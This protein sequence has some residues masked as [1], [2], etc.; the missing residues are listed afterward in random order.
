MISEQIRDLAARSDS[1]EPFLSFYMDTNRHDEQDR[2]R[3]RVSLKDELKD[4]REAVTSSNGQDGGFNRALHQVESYMESELSPAS[5]GVAFFCC[6]SEEFFRAL[7]LPFNVAT[8]SRVGVRPY[9]KPLNVLRQANPDTLIVLVD[10]KSARLFAL[11]FGQLLYEL[12]LESP[13]LP[14][15]LDQGGWSP[16]NIQRHVQDHI[17]RLHKEVAETLS[18]KLD[19]G[20]FTGVI[21]CG[22]ERNIANFRNFLPKRVEDRLLGAL[23][24][25]IRS[26]SEEVI[27]ACA[28]LLRQH[29]HDVL[30]E[31]LRELLEAS[32]TNGAGALGFAK[33]IEATNERRLMQLFVRGDLD[34]RGWLCGSCGM[35]GQAVPLGCPACGGTVSTVDLGEQLMAAAQRENA[36]VEVV[37]DPS[38]LQDYEG[39]GALLRF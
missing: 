25:G 28:G 29:S 12:D 7:E 31:G 17:D 1:R 19:S 37:P 26:S 38:L 10:A 39:V 3:I 20:S 13:D 33:V 22:Q 2:E 9:L 24:L 27:A 30:G 6:P 35:I 8:E 32:Q 18:R 34:E 15:G 16:A 23:H 21:L 36:T 4:I 14:R 5:R 11:E